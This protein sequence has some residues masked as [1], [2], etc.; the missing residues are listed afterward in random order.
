MGSGRD[1]VDE[2]MRVVVFG[3]EPED[4]FPAVLNGGETIGKAGSCAAGID[5][6]VGFF[7][8]FDE[9]LLGLIQS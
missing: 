5:L 8:L 4:E 9:L 3:V 6:F 1:F 2:H 7:R